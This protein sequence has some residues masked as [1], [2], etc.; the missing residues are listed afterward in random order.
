MNGA[1][2]TSSIELFG[3]Q[4]KLGLGCGDIACG[5]GLPDFA[6]LRFDGRFNG[7]ILCTAFQALPQAFLGTLGRWHS[8]KSVISLR[9]PT[10]LHPIGTGQY[11][12]SVATCPAAHARP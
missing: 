3:S 8:N 2:D 7:T 5:D 4:A 12:S 1:F 9:L 11:L 10:K 6:D